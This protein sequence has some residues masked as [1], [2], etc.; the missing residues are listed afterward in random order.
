MHSNLSQ[1]HYCIANKVHQMHEKDSA[2][3]QVCF[4]FA[5]YMNMAAPRGCVYINGTTKN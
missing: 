1:L 4:S 5:Y 2:T 3:S